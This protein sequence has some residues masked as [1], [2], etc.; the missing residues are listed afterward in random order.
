MDYKRRQCRQEEGGE[1]E[2]RV[3]GQGSSSRPG[4][5]ATTTTERARTASHE[6]MMSKSSSAAGKWIL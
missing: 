3:R 6:R 1:D 5:R 2:R 4:V